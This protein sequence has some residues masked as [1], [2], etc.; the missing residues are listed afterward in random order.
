M[1]LPA[2]RR[3]L[4]A[5]HL[6]SSRITA[7]FRTFAGLG[8]NAGHFLRATV[9]LWVGNG[10]FGVLFN[11][12][13][14]SLGYNVTFVAILAAV[15]TVGQAA[16]SFVLGPV[17]RIWPARKVMLV[18]TAAAACMM[19]LSALLR[20]AAALVMVTALLGASI[21]AAAIPASPFIS[22][23]APFK[24]R[25]HLFSAFSAAATLGSMAGSLISG[26]LPL[27]CTL[28][29]AIGNHALSQ[30]R[31]GLLLGAVITGLGVWSLWQITDATVEDTEQVQP[32]ALH[33]DVAAHDTARRNVLVMM[34]ATA[35]IALAL[36]LIYPLFNMYFATVHHAST[37]SIGLLFAVSGVFCTV[38]AFLAPVAA[39][40]GVPTGFVITRVLTAPVFLILFFQPGFAVASLAYVLRNV[41]GQITGTLENT[42]TM[43][44]VPPSLR[45]AAANWRTFAYNVA[46]TVA[47][48]ISGVVVAHFGFP[49]VFVA[50]AVLTVAG[51][52]VWYW[53]FVPVRFSSLST[54]RGSI[55]RR[56]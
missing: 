26:V 31:I 1:A 10:I 32:A 38:A 15:S 44:V 55:A 49:C 5:P 13:L 16:V 7:Y 2:K 8:A 18:A 17:L 36:G 52:L 37:A 42:F 28:I 47:S 3:I 40:M 21:A 11:L 50:S 9:C 33:A 54:L 20:P 27:V 30:D 14:V 6:L 22:S 35:L 4:A 29:P 45:A 46:W 43:E 48:V 39:R 25:A 56:G 34:A 53:G 24:R 23:Q 51:S 19:A 12:Y 41:L